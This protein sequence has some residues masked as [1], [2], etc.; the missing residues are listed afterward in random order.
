MEICRIIRRVDTKQTKNPDVFSVYLSSFQSFSWQMNDEGFVFTQKKLR[1]LLV[2][3]KLICRALP[4]SQLR[5]NFL[6]SCVLFVFVL[7]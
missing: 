3:E 4:Q 2:G 6:G 5:K 1:Q 7:V